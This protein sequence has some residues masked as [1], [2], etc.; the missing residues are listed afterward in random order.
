LTDNQRRVANEIQT[1]MPWCDQKA[2]SALLQ[3][4][5]WPA[6]YLDF[7][8]AM[9]AI[10][11]WPDVAPHEQVV[12]QYSIHICD[13]PGKTVGHREYLADH[14]RDC[15]RELAE[16]LIQDL[17]DNGSI[18]TYSQFERTTINGLAKRFPDLAPALR[19]CVDRLFDLEKVFKEAISHPDF[20]GRSSIKVTLPALVPSMSYEGLSIGDGD[21]ALASFATM[22][23]GQCNQVEVD[24]I[25]AD[26]LAYCKQDTLAMVRL[27]ERV[28][29]MV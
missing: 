26:L 15:R 25:R 2:M 10:P 9:T 12:T 6:Y 8:T 14:T 20:H 5:R 22:A 21:C 17:G 24:Q 3:L 27:H 28:W 18:V 11:L 4:V 1:A 13:R 29:R 19:K 23:S 16:R 7:E